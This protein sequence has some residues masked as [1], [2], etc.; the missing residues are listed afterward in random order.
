MLELVLNGQAT[1]RVGEFV[2]DGDRL[3]ATA[4]ELTDLG[5]QLPDSLRGKDGLVPLD[6][7]PGVKA[8]LDM[9][10]QRV[11]VTAPDA[12]LKPVLI[13]PPDNR[14]VGPVSPSGTGAV[15]NYDILGTGAASSRPSG[16]ANLDGRFFSP[17]GTISATAIASLPQSSVTPVRRLDSTY[18]YDDADEGR[19]WRAGDLLAGGLNWSRPVRLLGGQL[20]SDFTL[21]PDLVTTAIPVLT[22]SAAVPSTVDVLIDGVRQYSQQVQPG[23]F[24]LRSLPTVNGAGEVAVAVQDQLGRQTL[25]TLPFYASPQLLAPDLASYSI[26]LGRVRQSYGGPDD[27]YGAAAGIGSLRYGV[28]DWLTAEAHGEF[29]QS[30]QEAGAGGVFRIGSLGVV[31]LAGAGSRATGPV[32]AAP[33]RRASGGLG[34][35]S[36]SRQAGKMSVSVAASATTSGFRDT[37]AINGAPNPRLQLNATISRSFGRWGGLSLGYVSQQGGVRY[38]A[39]GLTSTSIGTAASRTAIVTASYSVRLSD[40]WGLYAN[41]FRDSY[42]SSFG[43]LIGLTFAPFDRVSGSAGVSMDQTGRPSPVFQAQRPTVEPGDWG[44][45]VVDQEGATTSRRADADYLGTWGRPTVSVAQSGRTTAGQAGLSGALVFA[46]RTLM[47][48][49]KVVDSFAVVRTGDVPDVPVTFENRPVGATNADGRLLVPYLSGYQANSIGVDAN[50]LPPDVQLDSTSQQVRPARRSGTIVDF[51]GRRSGGALVRLELAPGKPV[52]LGAAARLPG[53]EPVP[54]G[55]DGEAFVTGLSASNRLEV[56]LPGGG[57][58]VAVFAYRASPGELPTIG[59][60]P[61]KAEP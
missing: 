40:S 1:G 14:L 9:A 22:S 24:Q 50:R 58:C 29:G 23:P 52:P 44:L 61:C 27:G 43:V 18:E 20:A 8:V 11:I 51:G 49:D 35:A 6:A 31:T 7:L 57:R 41:A 30:L 56:T 10:G 34:S 19:I 26:D 3:S 46:D 55:Y 21:R 37:A 25:V 42:G 45:A 12:L 36:V 60:V 53:A 32:A 48:S 33:R 28:T 4:T 59:P 47:L 5:F 38:I 54:V 16:G 15:F 39:P 13:G 2:A 17:W